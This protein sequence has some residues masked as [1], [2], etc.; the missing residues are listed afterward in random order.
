MGGNPQQLSA[1]QREI[2]DIVNGVGYVRP[3][4]RL[5]LF[6]CVFSS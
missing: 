1:A 3:D 5:A 4:V 2:E 6:F